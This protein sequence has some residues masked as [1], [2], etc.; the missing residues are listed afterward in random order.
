MTKLEDAIKMILEAGKEL[1]TEKIPLSHCFKQ[2]FSRR[3][4]HRY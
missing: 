4:F 2:G 3:C 1:K